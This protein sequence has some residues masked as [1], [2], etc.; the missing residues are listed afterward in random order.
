MHN[1]LFESLRLAMTI[2]LRADPGDAQRLVQ[3]K[4]R[5]RE[6]EAAAT[7]LSVQR[8]RDATL[9]SRAA[10]AEGATAAPDE[11]GVLRVVR[12]LRRIHSHL[13][14]FAYPVLNRPR[15]GERGRMRSRARA[16]LR[17][18]AGKAPADAPAPPPEPDADEDGPN[19]R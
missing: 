9:A 10:G 4:A 8:L 17:G 13:A 7:A 14:S 16:A 11:S 1:E 15:A 18:R 2:F 12:D 6:M 5:L 3:R 19:R